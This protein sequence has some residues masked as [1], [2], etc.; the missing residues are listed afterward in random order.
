MAFRPLHAL[1]H[2]VLPYSKHRWLQVPTMLSKSSGILACEIFPINQTE[3]HTLDQ[4]GYMRGGAIYLTK[5]VCLH[6][7][8]KPCQ[9]Q[10]FKIVNLHSC[11]V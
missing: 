2:L 5:L 7:G 4:E 6:L 3:M 10:S 1:K 9:S 11:S 8:N